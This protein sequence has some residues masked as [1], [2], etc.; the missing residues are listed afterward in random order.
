MDE[1]WLNVL[2]NAGPMVALVMFFVWSDAKRDAR[3][4]SERRELE[5][6]VRT[7]LDGLIQENQLLIRQLGSM[8]KDD[9]ENN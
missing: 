8:I 2:T 1:I 7:K 9:R 6:Y 4:A 5:L 3:N